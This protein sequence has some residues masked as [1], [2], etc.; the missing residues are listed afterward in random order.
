MEEEADG[1]QE[2]ME[3]IDVDQSFERLGHSSKTSET[4]KAGGGI[5]GMRAGVQDIGRPPGGIP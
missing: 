3:E 1:S 5:T 2:A 4:R